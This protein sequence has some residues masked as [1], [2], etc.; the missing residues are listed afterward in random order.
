MEKQYINKKKIFT[1]CDFLGIGAGGWSG[2]DMFV[3]GA[4]C[5]PETSDADEDSPVPETKIEM[6]SKNIPKEKPGVAALS[7][8]H[9]PKL[10]EHSKN[11]QW[12][13]LWQNVS[14]GF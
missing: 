4:T 14:Q 6:L 5:D 9:P 1:I 3:D 10:A 11:V 7:N 8:A 13:S 12:C 2:T